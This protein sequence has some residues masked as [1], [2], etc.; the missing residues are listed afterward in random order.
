[1]PPTATPIPLAAVVDGHPL[2][3]SEFE[4]E[5]SR[6]EA[7]QIEAGIE[8]ATMEPYR[9]SVLWALI[10]MQLLAQEATAF[11]QEIS[12]AELDGLFQEITEARG[13]TESM[14]RWLAGFGY[15]VASLKRALRR[16]ELA[17]MTVEKLADGVP[18]EVEQVHAR[19]ILVADRDL[20]ETLRA[21]I[22]SGA[23]F[24][25]LAVLHS[26]DPSTKVGGGDLGWFP[27]GILT[28]PEV[29]TAAFGLEIGKI[30]QVVESELGYHLVQVM[31]KEVAP[32]SPNDLRRMRTLAVENWLEQARQSAQIE[33]LIEP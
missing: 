8:L 27:K 23:E 7:A 6:Y 31:E 13:G 4:A 30:S 22:E 9:E 14:A 1:V 2:A 15:D 12:E 11:G 20:A 29:E 32:L 26:L 5:V 33:I 25:E 10:D 3:L 28:Q 16:E 24:G 18:A 17:Q 21:E 19:H